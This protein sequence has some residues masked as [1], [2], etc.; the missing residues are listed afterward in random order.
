MKSRV[1]IPEL[2]QFYTAISGVLIAV[3]V[4]EWLESLLFVLCH[5]MKFFFS[6]EKK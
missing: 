3:A 4:K 1:A 5:Y 2:W 6:S